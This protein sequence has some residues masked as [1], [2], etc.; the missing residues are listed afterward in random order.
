MAQRAEQSYYFVKKYTEEKAKEYF[1]LSQLKDI[2]GIWESSDGFTYAIETDFEGAFANPNKFRMIILKNKHGNN[3][4]KRTFIKGFIIYNLKSKSYSVKYYSSDRKGSNIMSQYCSA[5][6]SGKDSFWFKRNDTDEEIFMAKIYPFRNQ[7]NKIRIKE[8]NEQTKRI[9][10]TGFAINKDGY[11]LTNYR[12]IEGAKSIKIWGINNRFFDSANAKTVAID[13]EKDLALLQL[14]DPNIFIKDSIPYIFSRE[15]P[16]PGEHIL[17]LGYYE[18]ARNEFDLII[19][20]GIFYSDNTPEKNNNTFLIIANE[21]SEMK[22]GPIFDKNGDL[23]GILNNTNVEHENELS[24]LKLR[25]L[26]NLFDML[27]TPITLPTVSLL[28]KKSYP[29]RVKRTKNFI[30]IVE[31]ER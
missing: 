5:T 16:I 19:K 30:Y 13:V 2:E 18:D 11:I 15:L 10:G 20:S 6:F 7:N 28:N 31:A 21:S 22:S 14:N 26:M 12:F 23:I 8:S 3:F 27:V 9:V 4:W 25:D 29:A 1:D 17:A 24:V